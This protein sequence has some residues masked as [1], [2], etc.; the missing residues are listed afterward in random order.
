[1]INVKVPGKLFIA[2]EYAVVEPGNKAII[3]AVDS[4]IHVSIESAEDFGTLYSEGLISEKVS[5]T[6]NNEQIFLEDE[7]AFSYI[8]RAIEVMEEYVKEVGRDL[9]YFHLRIFNELGEKDGRKYGLGSS[10][11]VVVAVVRALN[12]FYKLDLSDLQVFKLAVIISR[13]IEKKGSCGDIAASSFAQFISYQ[14]FD[15]AWFD[16][17]SKEITIS[18]M[19]E[20]DWPLLNIQPLNFPENLRFLIGWTGKA[21]STPKLVTQ[22]ENAKE[23]AEHQQFLAQSNTCVEELIRAFESKDIQSIFTQI[24]VNR[25]LLQGLQKH[26]SVEIETDKLQ[27]LIAIANGHGAAAK[28]SGAGGGDCGIA[29]IEKDKGIDELLKEWKAQGIIPLRFSIYRTE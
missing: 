25:K 3:T 12:L 14:T 17:I 2:G 1:M 20:T 28:T 27:K 8:A 24:A 13:G 29:F 10:G 9:S 4:F 21:A 7:Q 18:Q 23:Q 16:K 6:R 15:F 5:W 11:A 22:V 19:V 26:T